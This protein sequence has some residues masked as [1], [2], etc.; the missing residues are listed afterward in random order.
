[1]TTSTNDC[2]AARFEAHRAHLLHLAHR[3][4]GTQA[5]AEDVVQETYVRWHRETALVRHPRQW[6]TTVCTRL[7]IDERRS[8]RFRRDSYVGAWLPEPSVDAEANPEWQLATHQRLSY[9][10]LICLQRLNTAERAAYLLHHV[11]GYTFQEISKILQRPER[12]CRKLSSRARE[13]LV[14]RGSLE[15][16]DPPPRG[17]L[18][19]RFLKALRLADPAGLERLLLNDAVSESDSGGTVP[20]ATKTVQ[21]GWRVARLLAGVA[22]KYQRSAK[23][24]GAQMRAT[25]FERQGSSVVALHV[26]T[27]VQTALILSSQN[28]ALA[29]VDFIRNP[30]KLRSIVISDRT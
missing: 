16:C 27:D 4:L 8:S 21:G 10:V 13:A 18:T 11:L 23:R 29:R 30:D 7:C 5:E 22:S 17:E 9:A 1:M 6:L 20:A 25:L 3:M 19:Q 28:C 14:T 24:Q 12:G 26:G 2:N 15:L